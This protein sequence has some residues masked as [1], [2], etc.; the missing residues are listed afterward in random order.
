DFAL[1]PDGSWALPGEAQWKTTILVPFSPE[2]PA[3]G[4]GDTGFYRACW[5]RRTFEKPQLEANQHLLLN[6]G[7][8][9]YCATVWVNGQLA[10]SHE[11]GYT[12]FHLDITA[13]LSPDSAQTIVVRAQDDPQDLAKPRGKQD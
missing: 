1:D 8:V 5:Y 2:T 6:F 13:L 3:S 9:D 11:G 12:P 10:G 4:I 7:A